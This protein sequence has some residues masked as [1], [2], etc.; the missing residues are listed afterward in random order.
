MK[1]ASRFR[2][3]S[4]ICL[5]GSLLAVPYTAEAVM[6]T[7][8]GKDTATAEANARVSAVRQVMQGMAGADFLGRNIAAVRNSIIRKASDFSRG[9]DLRSSS[10]EGNL[11]VIEADV[12]VDLAA[13]AVALKALGADVALPETV[14]APAS[15]TAAAPEDTDPELGKLTADY[16]TDMRSLFGDKFQMRPQSV[17]IPM[18]AIKPVTEALEFNVGITH[19]PETVKSGEGFWFRW[20]NRDG[21]NSGMLWMCHADAAMGSQEEMDRV[22][23]AVWKL[24]GSQGIAYIEAPISPGAYELRLFPDRDSKTKCIARAGFT[25]AVDAADIPSIRPLRNCFVP[26]EEIFVELNQ[27]GIFPD[28]QI[29]I[30]KPTDAS[31]IQYSGIEIISKT[32]QLREL[33]GTHFTITAPREPGKYVF[34]IFPHNKGYSNA[35]AA[36]PFEV[37]QPKDPEKAMLAVQ[38]YLYSSER[39]RFFARSAPEWEWERMEWQIRRKGEYENWSRRNAIHQQGIDLNKVNL[40]NPNAIG[41]FFD[42]GDYTVYLFNTDAEKEGAKPV[43]QKDF[44][45][46]PAPRSAAVKP[47]LRCEPAEAAPDEYIHV[48]FA[49]RQEWNGG[50]IVLVPKATPG[51]APSAL[52]VAG[53]DF[54][55]IMDRRMSGNNGF[56]APLNPGA[57]EIRL[58][59]GKDEKATVQAVFPLNVMTEAQVK[60]RKAETDRLVDE[61]LNSPEPAPVWMDDDMLRRQ[62]RV[63]EIRNSSPSQSTPAG[64]PAA[65]LHQP[66]PDGA[67]SEGG[68]GN[69]FPVPPVL[70]ASAGPTQGGLCGACG[71]RTVSDVPGPTLLAAARDTRCDSYI[72]EEIKKMRLV[73]ITLG[74]DNKLKSALW[75][76]AIATVTKFPVKGD[77]AE[78]LKKIVNIAYDTYSHSTAGIDAYESGDYLGAAQNAFALVLKGA[79][80]LCDSKDCFES[81]RKTSDEMLKNYLSQCSEGE[82]KA[83][84]QKAS[85]ELGDKSGMLRKIESMRTGAD[86]ALNVDAGTAASKGWDS[87]DYADMLWTLGEGAVTTAW[88]PAAIIIGAAKVT[89]EGALAAH[90]FIVDDSTQTLYTVYKQNMDKGAGDRDFYTALSPY[91]NTHSLTKARKIMAANLHNPNVLKALSGEHRD[92]A[93]AGML[94]ADDLGTEEIWKYLHNQFDAWI[95]AEKSNNDFANYAN[96]LRDDY[97][98]MECNYDFDKS[99][100]PAKKGVSERMSSWWNNYCPD[101]VAR[102]R[103]Y[104]KART[105]IEKE[106]LRWGIGGKNDSCISAASLREDSRDLLCA[107]VRGGDEGY[108]DRVLST[109]KYCGW[110]LGDDRLGNFA[111]EKDI[112]AKQE[113]EMQEILKRQDVVIAAMKA[114]GRTD[115]LNCLCCRAGV[116]ASGVHCGYDPVS[117]PK[118]SP[119]CAKTSPPCLGG[120]WGCFRF[121]MATSEEAKESC[122]VYEAVRQWKSTQGPICR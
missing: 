69:A 7:V 25:V 60:A 36:L 51:D 41:Q 26:E 49:G 120:N 95:K 106:L 44:R 109:A 10:K 92:L 28:G 9:V 47:T 66:V 112:K 78:K 27:S 107:K 87:Q 83:L 31:A 32:K 16:M 65:Y 118:A 99:R 68:A 122:G 85:R 108:L 22:H 63:P 42:P 96:S 116:T 53:K 45:V 101:E 6:V 5:A 73:D 54:V 64:H 15:Q 105:D 70:V 113:A 4:A 88:P 24:E 115:I 18:Q 61:L 76:A 55:L 19:V 75:D 29:V 37:C 21:A 72:D 84:L 94:K 12:D 17:P 117:H 57:Y 59:D 67:P 90:D 119:S 81:V 121:N 82:Y 13:L 103:D 104:V 30:A 11:T 97:R 50:C 23:I 86:Y 100:N 62:F 102:F 93:R 80:N 91:Q 43:L 3:L 35:L 48:A 33:G 79:V 2:F 20:D 58:Y 1:I 34:Y 14:K 98:N 39:P 89:K 38:P 110:K 52:A 114:I 111:R 46:L 8:K 56:N 74:R 40:V 77:K 71:G